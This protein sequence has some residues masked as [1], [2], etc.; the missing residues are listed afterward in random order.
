MQQNVIKG[1]IWDIIS[2]TAGKEG[3][4]SFWKGVVPP[5]CNE[6]LL[7]MVYF[8]TFSLCSRWLKGSNPSHDF[9]PFQALVAGSCAGVR[10]K[11][12][13]LMLQ[14]C[15]SFFVTVS[16]LIKIHSQLDLGVGNNRRKPLVVMKDIYRTKGFL[17]FTHGWTAVACRDVPAV[18]TFKLGN[19]CLTL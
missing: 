13:R 9:N 17:G 15:G 19:E 4:W 2:K 18:G 11:D 7:N 8:G 14:F 1:S 16:D 5:L 3:V 12:L 10:N 6:G